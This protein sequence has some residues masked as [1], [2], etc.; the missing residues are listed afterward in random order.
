MQK[1]GWIK[2]ESGGVML[3]K[4]PTDSAE[5]RVFVRGGD[6]DNGTFVKLL[7]E[8]TSP[9]GTEYLKVR[10]GLI[11]GY[12]KKA[13][14]TNKKEGMDSDADSADLCA[15]LVDSTLPRHNPVLYTPSHR[16]ALHDLIPSPSRAVGDDD[17]ESETEPESDGEFDEEAP[18][19]GAFQVESILS[20][21]GVG[22]AR[23]YLV[24]WEGH[25]EETWEP[26]RNFGENRVLTKYLKGLQ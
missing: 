24:K 19:E 25:D 15:L 21:R 17:E 22:R 14:I 16:P 20:H 6:F 3:R 2:H 1:F 9:S 26:A 7:E 23:E 4:Q 5:P 8:A 12:V 10:H 18:A 11:V 13:Y